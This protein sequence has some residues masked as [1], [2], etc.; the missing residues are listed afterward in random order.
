GGPPR[1]PPC[2]GGPRGGRG[3][4]PPARCPPC[5]CPPCPAGRRPPGPAPRWCRLRSVPRR[6]AGL[7]LLVRRAALCP[8]HVGSPQSRRDT[9]SKIRSKTDCWDACYPSVTG[10]LSSGRACRQRSDDVIDKEWSNRVQ[11]SAGKR[12]FATKGSA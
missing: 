12:L 2:G 10:W 5:P 11:K 6:A 9:R 4:L 7:P 3:C 8:F 1:P